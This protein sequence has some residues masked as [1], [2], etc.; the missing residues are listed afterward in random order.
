MS[1]EQYANKTCP[2]CKTGFSEDDI[3]VVCSV[4]EMP[5]H[6]EC[7]IEN[8][9]C[10][11]FG[12]TGTITFPNGGMTEADITFEG[13]PP[14]FCSRCGTP[15]F[16]GTPICARCGTPLPQ[17]VFRPAA[18]APQPG[19]APVPQPA[20]RP[21]P[22]APQP[23]YAPVPQPAY[24][25]VPPAPQPGYAPVPQ[26]S[27][28]PVPPAPQPG[29]A[30][31]PQPGYRPAVPVAVCPVCGTPNSDSKFCKHCGTPLR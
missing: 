2:Y 18:P 12:C 11:T 16:G 9:A 6:K 30:P 14:V 3:V 24:R 7:W 15:S 25:P 21:V 26:P 13:I 27:Y 17:P 10:T 29:Y 22:P 5:H 28:R 23:S 19:Y 20:Y 8:T 31:V 4:C 1:N